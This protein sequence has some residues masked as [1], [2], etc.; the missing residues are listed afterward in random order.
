MNFV[1]DMTRYGKEK[2]GPKVSKVGKS[3]VWSTRDEEFMLE[4]LCEAITNG[5]GKAIDGKIR[6]ETF[7]DAIRKLNEKMGTSISKKHVENHMKTQRTKYKNYKII[8]EQSGWGPQFIC[9]HTDAERGVWSEFVEVRTY[10]CL[11]FS[12]CYVFRIPLLIIC[13]TSL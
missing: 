11:C 5:Y 1:V 12:I 13:F 9:S 4:L 2:V 10:S 7:A 3:F 6:P 8:A